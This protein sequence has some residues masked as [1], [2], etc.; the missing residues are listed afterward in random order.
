[1]IV[2]DGVGAGEAPDA[3]DYGDAGANS[4]SHTAKAVGGLRLPNLGAIGLGRI[5]T[6]Q[7]VS[8]TLD[9]P[10]G[11]GRMQPASPGKDTVSGHWELMGI[12]LPKPFPTYPNGFPPEIVRP[13][14]K[15]IGRE[16]LGNRPAS[17]TQII[18]DFLDGDFEGLLFAN[19]IEF[20]MVHGHR[21]DPKGYAAALEEF[22][23][24]LPEIRNRLRAGD[25]AMIVADHGVDP[26]APGT[27]HTRE[28]VPLLV[29]GPAVKRSIDLGTRQTFS[30]AAATIAE[31]F[32][33]ERPNH[34]NSFWHEL[35]KVRM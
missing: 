34:G 27:D 29:F 16:V 10:S 2:L 35:Q 6:I 30:D 13:F 17:G 7:G 26:T 14:V 18:D 33:V 19:L 9:W 32:A 24:Q 11:Y 12:R 31:V 21:R 20:D 4:L 1:M 25:L 28:C 5:A 3:V 22:D 15:R 8:T 23:G